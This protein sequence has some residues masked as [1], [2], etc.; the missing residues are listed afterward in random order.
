MLVIGKQSD[1]F[2]IVEQGYRLTKP[3]NSMNKLGWKQVSSQAQGEKMIYAMTLAPEISPNSEPEAVDTKHEHL[4]F[5]RKVR[6]IL[7]Y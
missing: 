1:A 2:F 7:L 4:M 5:I 3:G 6:L